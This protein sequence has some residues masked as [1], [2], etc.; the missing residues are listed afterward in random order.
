M[1]K[2]GF[3]ARLSEV[4]FALGLG[5]MVLSV[6]TAT[7]VVVAN[8]KPFFPPPYEDCPEPVKGIPFP[9]IKYDG[10]CRIQEDCTPVFGSVPC[11]CVTKQ[12]L[13][14]IGCACLLRR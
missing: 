14:E 4:A 8:A 9:C 12:Q 11:I 5:M 10:K 2:G 13:E 3:L 6:A 1:R 7:S